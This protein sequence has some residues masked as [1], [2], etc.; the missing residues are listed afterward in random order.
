MS[1][2]PTLEKLRQ[3]DQKF[4]ASL[5][6]IGRHCWVRWRRERKGGVKGGVGGVGS[7]IVQLASVAILVS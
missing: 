4:K 3:E 5:G 7:Y 1:E 6:H 2:I